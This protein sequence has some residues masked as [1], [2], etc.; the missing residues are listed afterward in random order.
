MI[1]ALLLPMHGTAAAP[2]RVRSAAP[3][4]ASFSFATAGQAAEMLGRRDDFVRALSPF[5]RS[6]RLKTPRNVSEEEYLAFVRRQ[7]LDWTAG[8]M[9]RVNTVLTS[10]G[11]KL[12]AFRPF[13]DT[14]FVFVKTSGLEE[15]G[16]AYTRG[17]AVF[18]PRA[19]LAKPAPELE[20]LVL[21]EMFHV[22][23]RGNPV[24][25]KALY[26]LIGFEVTDDIELPPS[27][28]SRKITNPDAPAIDSVIEL[29]GEKTSIHVAPILF[30]RTTAYDPQKGGE[31][32]DYLQFRLMV[33]EKL[34]GRWSPVLLHDEPRLLEVK[35]VPS[36]FDRIGRNTNYV[37]HPDEI[38]A[39]N[40][41]YLVQG[42]TDLPTPGLVLK[43]RQVLK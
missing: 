3:S 14:K 17:A 34:D 33:V 20:T 22:V 2:N 41:V 16:A 38:L 36:F 6:A 29:P 37:I 19:V 35:N 28:R 15:G 27:Y 13:A 24:L 42:R 31:F 8:E 25:R 43:M 30:S 39:D 7:S 10:T 18:L 23:S 40:F 12:A 5:D 1:L 32:F 9:A 21:H 26:A 4:G 11:A